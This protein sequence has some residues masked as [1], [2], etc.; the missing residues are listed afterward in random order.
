MIAFRPF[1]C[2]IVMLWLIASLAAVVV[3]PAVSASMGIGLGPSEITI[4]D[5][6]RGTVVD[7]SVTA[8]NVGDTDG[9][10]T[11]VAEGPAGNWVTFHPITATGPA[12]QSLKVKGRSNI[13]FIVRFTIPPDTANGIYNTT[14]RAQLR[15][16]SAGGNDMGVTTIMEATS[17]ISVTVSGVQKVSGTVDYITAEDTEVNYP[18]PIKVL[19]H[20][21][22]NVAVNPEISATIL[23]K[24]NI[25]DTLSY[26]GTPVNAGEAGIIIVRWN[27]TG[28]E[29]GNYSTRVGVSVAKT[30]IKESEIP[31][32]IFPP[33][34]LSRQG[35]LT[36]L[37]YDGAPVVGTVL[38]ITG[39]F[40]N[41]GTIETKAKLMGEIYRDGVLVDTFTSD[42]LSIP[43][44]S[45]G[46]LIHYLKLDA[47]GGYT[48]KS[49]VLYEGKKTPQKE[50]SFKTTGLTTTTTTGA[51]VSYSK[52]PEFPTLWIVFGV[53]GVTGIILII[54]VVR[55]WWI[56]R[57]N[58]A[59]FRKY[60]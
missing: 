26:S 16:V 7:R 9:N 45:K 10:I 5:A 13:P 53:A 23:G 34:T 36:A 6:L 11:L 48:I 29:P 8:F 4:T 15:P 41:T 46:E 49:Y 52:S 39:I 28:N 35:N 3:C 2:R 30:S 60:D 19:F 33:G 42:E 43:I 51:P 44:Y 20:N 38:K 27:N 40:E 25:I 21:T 18:L 58:P 57:Q 1:E 50:L 56:R 37:L 54:V 14:L 24:G 22:G 47:M 17:Q 31:F 55:R 32:R 12:L 59:L